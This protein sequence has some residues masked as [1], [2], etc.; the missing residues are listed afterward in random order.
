MNFEYLKGFKD[1]YQLYS[2]CKYAEDS[3]LKHPPQ[4]VASSRKAEEYIVKFIYRSQIGDVT[5]LKLS[6]M[7]EDYRFIDYVNSRTLLSAMHFVR[8]MGNSAL[9]DD[10]RSIYSNDAVKVLENLHMVVG[11]FSKM[12]GL[13]DDY[14]EFVKPGVYIEPKRE[15]NTAERAVKPEPKHESMPNKQPI[16]NESKREV[17]VSDEIVAKYGQRLREAKFDVKY[18]R[19]EKENKKLFLEASLCEAGWPMV[20]VKNQALPC[21]AGLNMLLDNGDNVDYVMYGRDN[22]PLAI[23]EFTETVNNLI[24]GRE[25]ANRQ[26]EELCKKY[27][28]KPVVY[29]TNGYLTYVIDQLGYKPRRVFQFHSIEEL[30]LLKLRASMRKDISSP[31]IDDN[32]TNRT[33]Q[34]LAIR[35]ACTAFQNMRR[36]ALLVMATGTGKTRVA[37]SLTDI[38]MK[39]NWAKNVLFLADRTSLVRQAHK[40]FNKLLPNVTT[41]V[42]SGSSMDRDENARVIFSTYQTMINLINDDTREFG[43]GRFDLI[44]ID[45]AHRSI[46]KKYNQLFHYFDA[47]MIGLTATPRSDDNKNTYE[48]FELPDNQPDYAYEL[49]EA[50]NDG[51]LVGFHVED[52]TTKAMRR[53]ICY[54][55]LSD[56][57]KESFEDAFADG[58]TDLDFSGAK[59][60]AKKIRD[61]HYINKGTIDVMLNDL[62][63]NGIKVNAGDKIGKTIIFASSHVEAEVIVERFNSLYPY[64]GIDFCKLIDSHVAESL[65]L[66]D[67]F[68]ERDQL[69]QIAVSVDM[70]D[71][72]ID[73]PDIVN[74]VFFKGV[75]AKIKFLQ[76]IGRGTRLSENLFGPGMDKKGFL[77]FDYYDNFNYFKTKSTWNT[78]GIGNTYSISNSNAYFAEAM[79][80]LMIPQSVLINQ[81]KLGIL[82]NLI[83]K[84]KLSP[85]EEQY[86]EELK[87]YF[88]NTARNL[89][90]DDISV[91]YN[92]SYVSKYRTEENWN[93]FNEKKIEEIKEYIIPLFPSSQDKAKIK[94]FDLMVYLIENQVP[95]RSLDA[96]NVA[97]IRFGYG[98]VF[99]KIAMMLSE[100]RKL[101]TI[102][103]VR[104]K[105]DLIEK[106]YL[107]VANPDE[108]N[109]FLDNFSVEKCEKIRLELRDL[110]QYIPDNKE[111]Y[112]FNAK[113]QIISGKSEDVLNEQKKYS[114]KVRDYINSG[115]TILSKIRNL[116]ELTEAE[117]T[118]LNDVF[119]K[120]LGSPEDYAAFIGSKPLLPY[121]RIQ[122]GIS[123]E[124]I[125]EKFSSFLNNT[126]LNDQQLT[127]MNQ[128][129]SYTKENG[130]I[131]Y[132]ILQ[133]VSP[134]CDIGVIDLFGEKIEYI[135][136]M[137]DILHR[138]VI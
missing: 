41:S 43:I 121:L 1:F 131:N 21:S 96:K 91:Q 105:S 86:K 78:V 108:K 102:P 77:V 29:Y 79:S 103:E 137:V 53:G 126:V 67:R 72:G 87:N 38:L 111:Y 48:I 114:E 124:A 45:E 95:K 5:G 92:M 100:L 54:D 47:L 66:I 44:I 23:V 69:P 97:K 94:T 4:S 101:K 3:A 82:E 127:Y 75:K 76:M 65:E 68:T 109:Y 116:D 135:K 28:Y 107:S 19:D 36:H 64:L 59:L 138:S 13:I 25:K 2:D 30:E 128:I 24:A 49:T 136:T 99:N 12:I 73:V 62:M 9:H 83:I 18:Q 40:N 17:I 117:K 93:S 39:N 125:E 8:K 33:Y 55:D 119:Q 26:A 85:F 132:S 11:E 20:T 10:N 80:D 98:N 6:A 133:S 118:E 71:T 104:K 42:Y 32:I 27:G 110:M 120:Q 34:K 81:Q 90:N 113:D 7:M 89:N 106:L 15:T 58:D 57:E 129:I 35:A 70:M 22:K 37:I 50:I 14:P 63:K 61:D 31:E 115:N 52:K 123:E 56:E 16:A 60:E 46:F 134:F 122:I 88:V 84:N 130:D 112:I 51:F 74:L